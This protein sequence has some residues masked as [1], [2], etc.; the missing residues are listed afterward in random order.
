MRES[1]YYIN[2]DQG[3][4]AEKEYPCYGPSQKRPPGG[5]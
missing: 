2:K 5:N 1:L 3:A 4:K